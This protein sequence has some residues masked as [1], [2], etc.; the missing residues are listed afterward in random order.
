MT[1]VRLKRVYDP[2]SADDGLRVLVDRL[3]PRGLKRDAARIDHWVKEAA[4]SAALRRWFGH[5]PNRWADFHARYR[6]ELAKTPEAMAALRSL[7]KGAES[8]TLLFAAKD[9]KHNNAVVL[10][11]LL[12]PSLFSGANCASGI[13]EDI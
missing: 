9:V 13:I 8:L 11:D 6:A 2:P 10:R 3:W 7:M 5:D 4:P 1:R 12:A